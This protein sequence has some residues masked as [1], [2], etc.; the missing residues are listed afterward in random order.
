MFIKR[1]NGALIKLTHNYNPEIRNA[2]FN[3]INTNYKISQ[4]LPRRV[5][6]LKCRHHKI[7]PKF[8]FNVTKHLDLHKN[9]RIRH[10]MKD[11]IKNIRTIIMTKLL[12]FEIKVCAHKIKFLL[13]MN[14]NIHDYGYL[15][16]LP[17]VN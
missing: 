4:A 16:I 10:R 6:L 7:T 1:K 15:R 9:E 8:I 13:N 14:N 17:F 3:Y 5:F 12:N 11:R 2:V